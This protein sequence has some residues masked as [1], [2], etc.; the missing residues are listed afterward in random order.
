MFNKGCVPFYITISVYEN[1]IFFHIPHNSVSVCSFSGY[2]IFSHCRCNLHF[3]MTKERC[4][5]SFFMCLLTICLSLEIQIF[6][7]LLVLKCVLIVNLQCLWPPLLLP[8]PIFSSVIVTLSGVTI[9]CS[10]YHYFSL[11]CYN[12]LQLL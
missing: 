3:L 1:S 8:L 5:T 6:F 11:P 4:S 7:L 9:F 10:Y 2:E 12:I